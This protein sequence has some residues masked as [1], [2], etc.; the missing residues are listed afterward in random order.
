[1]GWPSD[2]ATGER[3]SAARLKQWT[4]AQK[5][6]GGDVDG[7]AHILNN[8]S[9]L[10]VGVTDPIPGMAGAEIAGWVAFG[11]GPSSGSG[12]A[13]LWARS[14]SDKS[15]MQIGNGTSHKWAD[16]TGA[17]AGAEIVL[18]SNSS[19]GVGGLQLWAG[20]PSGWI[21]FYT[22]DAGRFYITNT[23]NFGFWTQDQFGAGER[24]LGIQN[25]ATVPGANPTGGGVLYVQAG[26]L[27]Y[28][29]SSGTVTNI[30]NA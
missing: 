27:K 3:I 7:G 25:C 11:S 9:K 15:I 17:D 6:W 30:A 16:T 1:M 5:A 18:Y 19:F 24:V 20:D 22:A 8:I 13:W 12:D 14:N 29:G 21:S 10:G 28:R 2:W 26:A 4:D 23:G